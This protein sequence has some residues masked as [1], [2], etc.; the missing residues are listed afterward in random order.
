[1][2]INIHLEY[3]PQCVRIFL[4]TKHSA[5]EPFTAATKLNTNLLNH[6]LHCS[7]KVQPA[8]TEQGLSAAA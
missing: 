2:E 7:H 8:L 5:R 6:N 4:A 3:K 1:M